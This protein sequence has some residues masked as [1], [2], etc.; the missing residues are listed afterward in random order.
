MFE[1]HKRRTIFAIFFLS[2][3]L[4]ENIRWLKLRVQVRR[5]RELFLAFFSN[6]D[7]KFLA[8]SFVTRPLASFAKQKGLEFYGSSQ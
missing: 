8:T 6:I 1:L 7:I 4:A 3:F 5:E 2:F